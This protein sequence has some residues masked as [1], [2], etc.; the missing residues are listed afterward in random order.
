MSRLQTIEEVIR[1]KI[2]NTYRDN[3][4]NARDNLFKALLGGSGVPTGWLDVKERRAIEQAISEAQASQQERILSDGVRE[5]VKTYEKI[6]ADFPQLVEAATA[7][8]YHDGVL[9][10]QP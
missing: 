5:F 4:A 7:D 10:T 1:E 3:I 2:L 9:D 6:I 8:A